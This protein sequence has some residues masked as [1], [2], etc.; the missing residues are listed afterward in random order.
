MNV[1]QLVPG[2]C[3]IQVNINIDHLALV[4]DILLLE[5]PPKEVRIVLR[6]LLLFLRGTGLA[7]DWDHPVLFES[8]PSYYSLL[9]FGFLRHYFY[10]CSLLLF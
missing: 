1:L 3:R 8:L 5:G 2:H 7:L 6:F 9:A 10:L 4:H